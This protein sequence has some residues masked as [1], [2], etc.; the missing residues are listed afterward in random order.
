MQDEIS[1]YIPQRIL[2]HNKFEG[3]DSTDSMTDSDKFDVTKRQFLETQ[4]AT[5]E[6][7]SIFNRYETFYYLF[8]IRFW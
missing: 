7:I 8:L 2:H 6:Y 5:R 3:N 1:G 4:L